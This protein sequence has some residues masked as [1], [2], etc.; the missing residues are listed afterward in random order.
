MRPTFFHEANALM[1]LVI[2]GRD[3]LQDSEEILS[4]VENIEDK[5]S[6]IL[7]LAGFAAAEYETLEAWQDKL[8][9]IKAAEW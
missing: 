3:A 8:L 1:T 7:Y 4:Y 6:V 2:E 9:A 5:D